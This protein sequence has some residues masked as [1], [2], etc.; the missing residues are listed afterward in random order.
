MRVATRE[1]RCALAG[2]RAVSGPCFNE[3]S[4]LVTG[5]VL[6]NPALN[7][8]K[9]WQAYACRPLLCSGHIMNMQK[10]PLAAKAIAAGH[11]PGMGGAMTAGA[12]LSHPALEPPPTFG[13]VSR[14]PPARGRHRLDRVA[15]NVPVTST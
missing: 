1:D 10:M 4:L 7:K 12:D 9:H 15:L 5:A 14:L 3:T 11:D 6:L 8:S 2:Y 13:D